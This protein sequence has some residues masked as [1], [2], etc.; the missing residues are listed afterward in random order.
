MVDWDLSKYFDT[1]D[2]GL[3][4][5]EAREEGCNPPHQTIPEKRCHAD[6][7]TLL[8]AHCKCRYSALSPWDW[9]VLVDVIGVNVYRYYSRH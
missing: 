3:L 5:N 2:H 7:A 6:L 9:T 4:L 8:R 1:I